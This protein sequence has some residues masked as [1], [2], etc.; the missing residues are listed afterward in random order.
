MS[1]RYRWFAGWVLALPLLASADEV[2]RSPL[3]PGSNVRLVITEGQAAAPPGATIGRLAESQLP[4]VPITTRQDAG[5]TPFGNEQTP[6]LTQDLVSGRV[7]L[8]A[9]EVGAPVVLV[10][11]S[12]LLDSGEYWGPAEVRRDGQRWIVVIESWTDDSP[13]LRIALFQS[14]HVLNLGPLEEAGLDLTVVVRPHFMKWHQ[15]GALYSALPEQTHALP[16]RPG[17]APTAVQFVDPVLPDP[18]PAAQHQAPRYWTCTGSWKLAPQVAAGVVPDAIYRNDQLIHELPA[19]KAATQPGERIVAVIV[20]PMLDQ[21]NTA[22][23]RRVTWAGSTATIDID[24][25]RDHGPRRKNAPW[26]PVV[27]V[28]LQVL[29]GARADAKVAVRWAIWHGPAIGQPG[30][31]DD[32]AVAALTQGTSWTVPLAR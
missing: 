17:A 5:D 4:T 2:I 14:A 31:L 10:L 29:P 20:G 32:A 24:V 30:V 16:A 3:L 19:V 9:L 25:W 15:D 8:A 1:T 12:T 27:F 7:R 18:L 13:R 21:G 26:S 28:P 23:V 11:I 22:T 6:Q